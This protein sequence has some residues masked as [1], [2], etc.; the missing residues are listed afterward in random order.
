M[1][2]RKV[3]PYFNSVKVQGLFMS[4]ELKKRPNASIDEYLIELKKLLG[5]LIMFEK[6]PKCNREVPKLDM[7]IHGC[8]YICLQ[9][10]AVKHD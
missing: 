7:T 1:T 10:G 6:C 8:C 3:R 5:D 2:E 9:T 4:I